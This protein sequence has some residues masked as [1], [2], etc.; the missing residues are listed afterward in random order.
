MPIP[1]G[2]ALVCFVEGLA[3]AEMVG[4]FYLEGET[5]LIQIERIARFVPP[6]VTI[7]VFYE[8]TEWKWR[9]RGGRVEIDPVKSRKISRKAKSKKRGR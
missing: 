7:A 9:G 8:H 4:G 2:M 1:D 5:C 6:S 3:P